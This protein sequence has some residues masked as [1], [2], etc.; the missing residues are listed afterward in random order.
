MKVYL[1][2]YWYYEDSETQ[3][4]YTQ[5]AMER[6]K[7]TYVE[8]G[9]KMQQRDIEYK[10]SQIASLEQKKKKVVADESAFLK[11]QQAAK[12]AGHMDAVKRIRKLRKPL[13]KE[14]AN[15]SHQISILSHDICQL[16]GKTDEQL[17]N[18]Y[19]HRNHLSFEEFYLLE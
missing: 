13:T 1:L 8:E 15:L 3:G 17:C 7:K 10:K 14:I 19:M 6:E 12:N 5:E 4:V 16:E 9:R 18:D 2:Q 11:D